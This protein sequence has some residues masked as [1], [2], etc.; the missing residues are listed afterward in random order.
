LVSFWRLAPPSWAWCSWHS[1]ASVDNKGEHDAVAVAVGFQKYPTHNLSRVLSP[2]SRGIPQW[3]SEPALT[4]TGTDL[5]YSHAIR[6]AYL[7]A[8][9]ASHS[10]TAK[11]TYW[12]RR[13]ALS[14]QL[15]YSVRRVVRRIASPFRMRVRA[16]TTVIH[17]SKIGDPL[18]PTA[19][20]FKT[21]TPRHIDSPC[22]PLRGHWQFMSTQTTHA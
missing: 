9:S 5:V 11:T 8:C 21:M 12:R 1:F 10:I 17:G 13:V 6:P 16:C 15:Q 4:S 7:K 20:T 19:S 3:V 22:A 18:A 14:H 2:V